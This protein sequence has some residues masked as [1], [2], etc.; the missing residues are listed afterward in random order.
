MGKRHDD[1]VDQAA[2]LAAVVWCDAPFMLETPLLSAPDLGIA[3]VVRRGGDHSYRIDV[4]VLDTADHRLLR[5]GVVLAHRVCDGVGDWYLA[6]PDWADLLPAEETMPLDA[7]G[8]LP[9]RFAL[10]TQPF[11]RLAPIGPVAAITL[12]R[13]GYT[14][15]GPDEVLGTIR[16]DRYT[17]QRGGLVIGRSRELTLGVSTTLTDEQRAYV[18][19]ALEVCGAARVEEFPTLRARIGAPAT[20]LRDLPKPV[21]RGSSATLQEFVAGVFARRLRTIV[22]ADLAERGGESGDLLGPQLQALDADV[23]GLAGVLQPDWQARFTRQVESILAGGSHPWR[24]PQSYLTLL[25]TLV[26]AARAPQLGDLGPERARPHLRHLVADQL[27]ATQS[28][29]DA[30]PVDLT[31]SLADRPLDAAQA[32]TTQLAHVCGVAQTVLGSP[33]RRLHTRAEGL[34]ADLAV[35]ARRPREPGDEALAELTVREA[36]EVGQAHQ[37]ALDSWHLACA[38]LA[39]DLPRERRRLTKAWERS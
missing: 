6:A 1:G 29:L 27:A 23:L 28:A 37:V 16:D 21:D 25:D 26:L 33:A 2:D 24:R 5:S 4:T 35:A 20:G 7:A 13:T 8:D 32:A 38:Q 31:D 3:R 39:A 36:F 11:R 30:L 17:V 19:A 14:L 10:L 9:E 22:E 34:A 15:R 18:L 12:E